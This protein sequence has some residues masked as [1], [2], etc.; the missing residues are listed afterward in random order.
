[1]K[2]AWDGNNPTVHAEASVAESATLV[3]KVTL[4]KNS[5]VWYGAVLR[6][7]EGSITIG[8]GTNIQD[9]CV[10]H[11]DHD[12]NITIGNNVTIGHGAIVHG[13]TIE[14]GCMIGMGAI[15]LNGC[16]IGA[17]AMI[18]AGALVTQ[19]TLIPPAVLAMGSPAKVVRPLKPEE[20]DG[21][22]RSA[23]TYIRLA[24]GQLPD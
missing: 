18:A 23:Q 7:D 16:V 2:M 1:M 24:K 8:Q 17:G 6:G 13:C 20:C 22:E 12:A 11:C 14:D 10:L 19:G 21:L 15:L 4:G 9:L 3:G 5:S